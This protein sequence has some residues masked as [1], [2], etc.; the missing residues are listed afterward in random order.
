MLVA[1]L[2]HLPVL[3]HWSPSILMVEPSMSQP[4]SRGACY[5]VALHRC[6]KP[7]NIFHCSTCPDDA[8]TDSGLPP[9]AKS[10]NGENVQTLVN[11]T[12]SQAGPSPS[13]QE[14][15]AQVTEKATA[16]QW[17]AGNQVLFASARD[18]L[19]VTFSSRCKVAEYQKVGQGPTPLAV[20]NANAACSKLGCHD[21]LLDVVA[22][23]LRT[24]RY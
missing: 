10:N 4:A 11:T 12:H 21:L 24:I 7:G 3:F 8:P 22:L 17:L 13:I 23:T 5:S 2:T 1:S 14:L 9:P 19:L 18:E 15:F 20:A 16:I 6:L